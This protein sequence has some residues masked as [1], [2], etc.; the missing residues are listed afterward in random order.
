MLLMSEDKVRA[1]GLRPRARV[2]TRVVVGSDPVTMLDGALLPTKAVRS[3][4]G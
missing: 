2:I 3:S 4:L 1:L